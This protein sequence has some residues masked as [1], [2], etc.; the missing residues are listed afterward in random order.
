MEKK[1]LNELRSNLEYFSPAERKIADAILADPKEF[2]SYSMTELSQL[3]GVSQGSII[4]FANKFAGGGFPVLKLHIA[5]CLSEYENRS[6]VSAA[7]KGDG[8][9][10]VLYKTTDGILAALR[11][12][13]AVNDE[14]VLHRAAERIL[15]AKK[16]EIYGVYR[17]AV[18]ATDFYYQLLTL[19][20]PAVFVSDVLTASVS[21]SLLDPDALVVAVS[22]SGKTK[23]VLDAVKIAKSRGVP[24]ISLTNHKNSPLAKL[25]NEV[26]VASAS[27]NTLMGMASEIRLSQLALTD[28]LCAYLRSRIDE[29]GEQQYFELREIISS[30]SVND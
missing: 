1:L 15:K 30:H 14:S 5:A 29:Q 24:V 17:S 8:V 21:A 19:G 7:E 18:V 11:N 13:E 28:A 6:Y 9:K 2:I 27:G 26:L 12:T 4:N 16:V 22:A 10:D 3:V 20:I 25:S 23:D